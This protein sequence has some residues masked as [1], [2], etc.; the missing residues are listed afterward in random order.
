MDRAVLVVDVTVCC[1]DRAV[2]VVDVSVVWTEL[3]WLLMSVL[4]GQSCTGC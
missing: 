2:L 1:V 3:Y 4:C